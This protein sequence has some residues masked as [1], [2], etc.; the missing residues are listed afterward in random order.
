MV[1]LFGVF[2]II[3][4]AA[5]GGDFDNMNGQYVYSKTPGAPTDKEFPTDYKDYPGGVEYFDVYQ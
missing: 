2:H 3:K 4:V 1:S 5:A